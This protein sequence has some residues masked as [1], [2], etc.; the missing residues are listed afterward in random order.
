M[1]RKLA[2]LTVALT[3]ALPAFADTPAKS[4]VPKTPITKP[5]KL[6]GHNHPKKPTSNGA[7]APC[8]PSGFNNQ[9]NG[10]PCK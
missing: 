3:L 2:L 9:T 5:G 8:I 6:P 4:P 7:L 1:I 10:R